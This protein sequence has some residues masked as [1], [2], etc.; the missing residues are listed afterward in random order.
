M[1][2][3][4]VLPV[5]LLA[6]FPVAAQYPY[7]QNPAQPQQNYLPNFYNRQTQP[8]SPYLNLLRG[9][10]PGI[11][12]YYGVR[13]GLPSGGA[14]NF[15]NARNGPPIGPSGNGFLPQAAVADD[16][17][18]P[19]FEAGG[20]PVTLRSPGHPVVYGNYFGNHGSYQS[21]Y[22]TNINRG[23]TNG[24]QRGTTGLG[25]IPARGAAAPRR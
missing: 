11:N 5:L 16:P 22:A 8:L 4:L 21:V 6:A 9:G 15:G 18:A 17:N 12:Y 20:Q 2:N 1:R 10:D 7:S 13:P 25:T 14:N 23:I 24:T 3:L 19:P